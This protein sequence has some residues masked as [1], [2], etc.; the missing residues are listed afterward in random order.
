MKTKIEREVR[1]E[2]REK[3][4][5]CGEMS[6][7]RRLCDCAVHHYENV[8]R[9]KNALPRKSRTIPSE[10]VLRLRSCVGGRRLHTFVR[11]A[12]RRSDSQCPN[13][14]ESDDPLIGRVH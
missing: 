10:T 13:R 12:A 2:L 1:E 3:E 9:A 8:H 11:L 4:K 7:N 6:R 5:T 14:E